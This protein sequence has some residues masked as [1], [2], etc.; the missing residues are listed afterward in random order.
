MWPDSEQTADLLAAAGDGN[1]GAVNR[2]LDRHRE[3]LRRMVELRMDQALRRRVDASD[4]VQDVLIEANRRLTEYLANPVLP[5]HLWLRHI[6]RDRVIDTHRRHRVA[7]KRSID[8]EQGQAAAG[9]DRSSLDLIA[10]LR[11]P[12]MTPAAAATW[13]EMERRFFAALDQLDEHDRE[14]LLMRHFEQL[15]NQEVATALGLSEPA[16]GM[17]Y[18]RAM[19][20]LRTFLAEPSDGESAS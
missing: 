4:I 12:E 1:P 6:A 11:D 10:Q 7:G 14:V 19:R 5:F 15:S 18:L 16:A 3:A 8:R 17:R 2:L 9:L 13:R 20:R